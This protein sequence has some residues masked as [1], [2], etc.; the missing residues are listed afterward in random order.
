MIK[1]YTTE[2]KLPETAQWD[3]T[4]W[5]IELKKA[6][7]TNCKI[8]KDGDGNYFEI[9]NENCV[10]NI[11]NFNFGQAIEFMKNGFNIMR[12]GWN[13]KNMFIYLNKGNIPYNP[14]NE[15]FPFIEGIRN[16]LFEQGD[17]GTITRLPNLNM[18]A[19]SGSTVTGWLASQTD[20]LA[21][22]WTLA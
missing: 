8:I 11:K 2:A 1:L 22:D 10:S 14:N 3:G 5:N 4:I 13:G 6:I 19:A 7:D 17:V 20:I 9:V 15:E 18:R 12:Q 16:E 21:E